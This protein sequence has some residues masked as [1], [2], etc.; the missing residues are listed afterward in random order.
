LAMTTFLSLIPVLS[1]TG[2]GT[3]IKRAPSGVTPVYRASILL[4]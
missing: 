4:V 2:G 3:Q 1:E